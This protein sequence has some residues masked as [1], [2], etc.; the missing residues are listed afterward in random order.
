PSEPL[1][2]VTEQN[3]AG[4]KIIQKGNTTY[5]ASAAL[6][7]QNRSTGG[8]S[9]SLNSL[10]IANIHGRGN[11]VIYDATSGIH[12]F[13]ISGGYNSSYAAGNI[14]IGT[15]EPIY[16]LDVQSGVANDGINVTQTLGHAA[17]LHLTNGSSGGK[18]WAIFSTGNGNAQGSGHFSIYDYSVFADRFFISGGST[19][20]LIA[21]GNIGIGTNSP[22]SK[23]SVN[24]NVHIGVNTAQGVHADY[25]LSVEGKI[26][27][28]SLYIT[29]ANG[30]NWADYVFADDY[31]LPTLYEIEK[32][33][34]ANKHLPE[35]PTTEEIAEKG[36]NV[37]EM[38]VL[39]L[40][41]I[42]EMTILMVKQQKQI[43][44][45]NEKVK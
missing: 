24:G 6:T 29:A 19:S 40:K 38:N 25:K 45:L 37:S 31:K 28:Q 2:I 42:E 12:R 18:H 44:A 35:I 32:Y 39:L 14:G 7:L 34:K 9:W 5:T 20:P 26:V 43:D 16:K 15:T 4:I 23:L 36:I 22:K 30:T 1:E 11:F 3:D 27:A 41:K 21:A 13:F 17:A 10:G 8:R 33:Y